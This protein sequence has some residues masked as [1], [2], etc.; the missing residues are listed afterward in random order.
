MT[1]RDLPPVFGGPLGRREERL[2]EMAELSPKQRQALSD[3]TASPSIEIHEIRWDQSFRSPKF[4]KG[5]LSTA[6]PDDPET[7]ARRFLAQTADLVALPEERVREG[8][9]TPP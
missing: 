1:P 2:T 8:P 7:I 6:S 4:I 5:V 3:L 9:A